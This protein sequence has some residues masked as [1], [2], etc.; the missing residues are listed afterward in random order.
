M[1]SASRRGMVRTVSE[2]TLYGVD[3]KLLRPVTKKMDVIDGCIVTYDHCD[4]GYFAFCELV[5]DGVRVKCLC[6]MDT[7]SLI[8]RIR[9]VSKNPKSADFRIIKTYRKCP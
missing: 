2:N 8:N 6:S 1:P 3:M 9:R 5:V 7:N 4:Q